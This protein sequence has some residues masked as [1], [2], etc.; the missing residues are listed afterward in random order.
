MSST[1][2]AAGVPVYVRV[3]RERASAPLC[4]SNWGSRFSSQHALERE[5]SSSSFSKDLGPKTEA[6]VRD[7]VRFNPDK[8]WEVVND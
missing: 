3:R 4:V 8:S 5:A 2:L 6:I 7:I 1:T